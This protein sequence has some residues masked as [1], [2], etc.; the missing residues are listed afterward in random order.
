[1]AINLLELHSC[2]HLPN[3]AFKKKDLLLHLYCMYVSNT[4]ILIGPLM[5]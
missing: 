1:M 5:M 4:N 3:V 2:S